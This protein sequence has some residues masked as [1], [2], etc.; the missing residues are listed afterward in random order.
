MSTNTLSDWEQ[1]V[2][3]VCRHF[4]SIWIDS[5]QIK[6]RIREELFFFF[7]QLCSPF[8]GTFFRDFIIPFSYVLFHLFLHCAVDSSMS[9]FMAVNSLYAFHMHLA[10]CK[11]SYRINPQGGE[12]GS[13]R[14]QHRVVCED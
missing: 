5:S 13:A 3:F 1:M 7:F 12:N 14:D 6:Q 10:S 2:Y 8:F 11:L 4:L 9:F